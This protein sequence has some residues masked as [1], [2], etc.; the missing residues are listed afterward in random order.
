MQ[1]IKIIGL[2][3]IFYDILIFKIQC[4]NRIYEKPPHYFFNSFLF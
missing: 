3:A 2:I 1:F 4:T